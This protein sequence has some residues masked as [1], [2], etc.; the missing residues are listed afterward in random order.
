MTPEE[1]HFKNLLARLENPKPAFHDSLPE[2]I[3]T[4]FPDSP[5]TRE[6]E[7]VIMKSKIFHQGRLKGG[8]KA[9][10]GRR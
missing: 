6:L 8:K 7:I 5:T 1:E 10:V 3:D 4:A 9:N 2:V